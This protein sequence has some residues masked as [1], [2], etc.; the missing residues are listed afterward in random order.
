[1]INNINQ[2]GHQWEGYD[3]VTAN[4]K[5]GWMS[6][7]QRAVVLITTGAV[8]YQWKVLEGVR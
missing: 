8:S 6:E 3:T 2:L 1:M 5:S 7:V 4:R